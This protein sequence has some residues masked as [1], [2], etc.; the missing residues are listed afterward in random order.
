MN[1][2]DVARQVRMELISTNVEMDVECHTWILKTALRASDV[3]LAAAIMSDLERLKLVNQVLQ[4]NPYLVDQILTLV[5][6]KRQEKEKI[7]SEAECTHIASESPNVLEDSQ[8]HHNSY[9]IN[10]THS[11]HHCNPMNSNVMHPMPYTAID[12]SAQ[13]YHQHLLLAPPPAAVS[14]LNSISSQAC[15]LSAATS[16]AA[17]IPSALSGVTSSAGVPPRPLVSLSSG[18]SEIIGTD[19]AVESALS[20]LSSKHTDELSTALLAKSVAKVNSSSCEIANGPST[21]SGQSFL[22]VSAAPFTPATAAPETD[23]LV[24][25]ELNRLRSLSDNSSQMRPSACNSTSIMMKLAPPPPAPTPNLNPMALEFVPSSSWNLPI[26][27]ACT[28]NVSLNPVRAAETAISLLTPNGRSPAP[29]LTNPIDTAKAVTAMAVVNALTSSTNQ[30]TE[31]TEKKNKK[32]K[33]DKKKSET[34]KNNG[35]S[36]VNTT[37]NSNTHAVAAANAAERERQGLTRFH[38]RLYHCSGY[39]KLIKEQEDEDF[40]S[41]P[42]HHHHHQHSLHESSADKK[43]ENTLKRMTKKDNKKTM[44]GETSP[45]LSTKT[46]LFSEN[47]LQQQHNHEDS[48]SEMDTDLKDALRRMKIPKRG[49]FKPTTIHGNQT[50]SKTAENKKNFTENGNVTQKNFSNNFDNKAHQQLQ[51]STH[52]LNRN[53]TFSLPK[54]SSINEPCNPFTKDSLYAKYNTKTLEDNDDEDEDDWSAPPGILSLNSIP[55]TS[56]AELKSG[57]YVMRKPVGSMKFRSSQM[58]TSDSLNNAVFHTADS[59]G[60]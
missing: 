28:L 59:T 19:A 38:S 13:Q 56:A 24:R 11:R 29:A 41:T 12:S 37:T 34:D 42:L 9:N 47:H 49:I 57:K 54:T 31:V 60:H 15:P 18:A 44:N 6:A 20:V 3:K 32:S 48:G 7:Q 35:N 39:D 17:D 36:G 51:A 14:L 5:A 58:S 23:N 52:T 30:K 10:N 1:R 43:T 25:S 40:A 55:A 26:E 2:V 45:V 50:K 27:A 22:T 53:D 4:D 8:K 21:T 46:P 33:T 16:I